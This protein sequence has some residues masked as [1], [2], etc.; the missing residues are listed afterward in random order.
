VVVNEENIGTVVDNLFEMR[1]PL[2][3]LATRIMLSH[4]FLWASIQDSSIAMNTWQLAKAVFSH[5]KTNLFGR[6]G[7]RKINKIPMDLLTNKPW[8]Y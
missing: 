8:R 4:I 3:E 2:T 6:E 1:N 7:Y 5:A